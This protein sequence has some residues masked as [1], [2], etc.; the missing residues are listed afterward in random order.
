MSIYILSFCVSRDAFLFFPT[1]RGVVSDDSPP[2]YDRTNNFHPTPSE[3]YIIIPMDKMNSYSSFSHQPLAPRTSS[4]SSAPRAP[5]FGRNVTPQFFQSVSIRKG[6]WTAQEEQYALFIIKQFEKGTLRECEN[7]ITLRAYL[8]RKL[9]CAPMRISKKYAGAYYSIVETIV[10]WKK[11]VYCLLTLTTQERVLE[12]S[13]TCPKRTP[14]KNVSCRW[15]H[16]CVTWKPSFTSLSMKK[17][18]RM[19][20]RIGI[21]HS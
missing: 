17:C 9:H 10:F 6:K 18:I 4:Q 21:H 11:Q 1:E 5:P 2:N 8:S 19:L 12:S 16:N 13:C 15:I 3:L 7:G 20:L 14:R